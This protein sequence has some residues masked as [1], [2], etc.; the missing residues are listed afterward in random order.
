MLVLA[1]GP[2]F[3]D[4]FYIMTEY[5]RLGSEEFEVCYESQRELEC[6]LADIYA[7]RDEIYLPN[8]R[9]RIS[10]LSVKESFLG[11][12]IRKH[13]DH[14]EISRRAGTVYSWLACVSRKAEVSIQ[15]ALEAK[16]PAECAYCGSMPCVCQDFNRGGAN[17]PHIIDEN[18]PK[19][20]EAWQAHLEALYGENNRSPDKGIW[21]AIFRMM[22][23]TN[24]M[25]RLDLNKELDA[26]DE[27]KLRREFELEIADTAAWLIAVCNL[28]EIDL[29]KAVKEH[30]G[31]GCPNCDGVPCRCGPHYFSTDSVFVPNQLATYALRMTEQSAD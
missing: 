15:S 21:F 27:E 16:F 30:Y 18:A 28:L 26:L 9:D 3:H 24:E 17:L 19:S 25:M 29:H 7:P 12:S 23:E 2:I 20:L 8:M 4:N 10:D 11:D 13:R 6:R 1:K 5:E 22:D 14:S 31:N